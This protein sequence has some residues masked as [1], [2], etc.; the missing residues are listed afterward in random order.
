M[1]VDPEALAPDV[2]LGGG[3]FEDE[4][5]AAEEEEF[6]AENVVEEAAVGS[7]ISMTIDEI[8]ELSGLAAGDQLMLRIVNASDDGES[9]D[10]EVVPA[11][12]ELPPEVGPEAGTEDLTAAL[13]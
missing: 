1:A 9:Y 4:E 3:G 11:E 13:L 5:F 7:T 8:P 12:E 6:D 2:G 10:L